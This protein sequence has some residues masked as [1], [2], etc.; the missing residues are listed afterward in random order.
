[1][2]G[3]FVFGP[4]GAVD[5]AFLAAVGDIRAHQEMVDADAVVVVEG[6]AEIIPEGV[7]PL[8]IPVLLAQ[9]VGEAQI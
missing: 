4:R 6:L 3:R 9:R 1:M 2:V 7:M 8:L 5:P